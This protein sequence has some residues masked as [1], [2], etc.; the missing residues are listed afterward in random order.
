MY[1]SADVDSGNTVMDYLPPER[2]RGITISSAAISLPWSGCTLNLIDTPG[3]ADFT[4]E[5]ERILRVLDGA[6]VL[7]DAS[8]GVEAQTV[9]V[10]RQAKS[11]KI[12]CVAFVNKMDSSRANLQSTVESM[13]Q[14]LGVQ[15]VL[16]QLPVGDGR[17]FQGVVDLLHM[18]ALM[19]PQETEGTSYFRVLLENLPQDTQKLAHHYREQLL[20]QVA[21]V[22]DELASVLLGSDSVS[23]GPEE[24]SLAL[25]RSCA[26]GAI[27]PVLCGSALRGVAIQPLMDAAINY[28]PPASKLSSRIPVVARG[29]CAYAFKQVYDS[30]RGLLAYV[31]VLSGSLKSHT[32]IYNLSTNSRERVTRVLMAQADQLQD[33]KEAGEGRIAV[34]V[35]LKNTSTGDTLVQSTAVA[36]SLEEEGVVSLLT[37]P[38][39][40]PPVF[41]CTV[42]PSSS[43]NQKN[44]EEALLIL[45][46]EDPSLRVTFDSDTGQTVL[47]GMG[48]LHLE[49]V[50][51]RLKRV[52]GVECELGQLQVA[53][54]ESLL[55]ETLATAALNRAIGSSKHSVFARVGLYP[56]EPGTG[57]SVRFGSEVKMEKS[58]TRVLS[59]VVE[60]SLT[61]G[62][63]LGFPV[64]GVS[65]C[66]EELTGDGVALLSAC[67]AQAVQKV[68]LSQMFGL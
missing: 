60:T 35:G 7:L 50:E 41:L 5:V 46:R 21:M 6:V 14:Q 15:P 25:Q 38:T 34:A 52:F 24:L 31:R 29:L 56:R 43:A 3:H 49:V 18:H 36:K 4:F 66:V 9:A 37:P 57:V 22:D 61:R 32:S 12:P 17:D 16:T 11:C 28:L 45:S 54:R 23:L 44:L 47:S 63:L 68:R 42:E 2:E 51:E 64:E 59:S 55:Q 13:E 39:V 20:E 65:V 33:V 1:M 10:W 62:P 30:H 53:Y 8:A 67:L 40:P 58:V 26:S 48:E 19:W 27:V